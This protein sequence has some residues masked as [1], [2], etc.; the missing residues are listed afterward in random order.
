MF[1]VIHSQQCDLIFWLILRSTPIR[2]H[3]HDR[4][5][6]VWFKFK[7]MEDEISNWDL[8]R[9]MFA[10]L[11]FQTVQITGFDLYILSKRQLYCRDLQE[12]GKFQGTRIKLIR[13][14]SS[15]QL[16]LC[17]AVWPGQVRGSMTR[18]PPIPPL[19]PYWWN[20]FEYVH[21]TSQFQVV[22]RRF[23]QMLAY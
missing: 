6:E 22:S 12:A 4:R 23:V 3:H 1:D 5:F 17:C 13:M 19:I 9:H 16:Y 15:R 11:P 18:V 14:N 2:Q 10:V 8:D 7:V 20:N 21:S